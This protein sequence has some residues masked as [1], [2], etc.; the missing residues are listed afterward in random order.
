MKAGAPSYAEL[1]TEKPN[2]RSVD[3]DKL[4][5]E[6]LVRLMNLED[7]GAVRAVRKVLPAVAKAVR[8][9]TAVLRAGGG[10]VFAGAGTS[11]RL[12]VLE[13]AECPPTFNAGPKQV[14]FV[15]AGGRSSVF[16]SREGAE[17]RGEDAA[18]AIRRSVSGRD[19]V[20]G[21]AAS[22]VTAFARSALKEARALGAKTV[23]VTCNPDPSLSKLADVVIAIRT[24]PEVLTGS[25]R[26]KAGTATKMALNMITTGA[27]VG[28]GKTYGR[29]MVDLQPRSKKLEERGVRLIKELGGVTDARARSLLRSSG[30]SVKVAILMA[31]KKLQANEARRLLRSHDG[32]LR[33]ALA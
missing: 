7:A 31:R 2:P 8:L 26:L 20:V 1:P 27:F 3:L 10:I 29:W 30:K 25:T 32:F 14:R 33:R 4:S 12:G 24:G 19:V 21:V 13:A 6:A 15:M 5:P 17:D 11:G 16:R 23:L 18:R 28:A 22:G 9:G